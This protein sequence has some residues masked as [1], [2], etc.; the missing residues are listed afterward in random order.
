M[1][2]KEEHISDDPYIKIYHDVLYD[3]E[4][5]KIKSIVKESVSNFAMVNFYNNYIKYFIL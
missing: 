4:I 3:N 1:P 2:F 5:F